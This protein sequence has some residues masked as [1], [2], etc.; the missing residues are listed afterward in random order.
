MLINKE[1]LNV[2]EAAH[3][4]GCNDQHI[5]KLIHCGFLPAYKG[6]AR[7]WKIPG[8]SIEQYRNSMLQIYVPKNES[9]H[10]KK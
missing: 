1:F 7:R 8:E 9:C 6:Q 4:L 10:D 3:E 5:Y 2:E